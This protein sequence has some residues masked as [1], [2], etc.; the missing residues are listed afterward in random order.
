MSGK[1]PIDDLFARGLRDAEATPPPAVWK[2][3]V[4]E[5]D[6]RGAVKRRSWWGL[7]ALLLLFLGAAGYWTLAD[8][9]RM[10]AGENSQ[11]EAGST[12]GGGA[13]LTENPTSGATVLP[14]QRSTDG[15]ENGTKDMN[16]TSVGSDRDLTMEG[17]RASGSAENALDPSPETNGSDR[18][19]ANLA[20]EKSR[21]VNR[22]AGDIAKADRPGGK[23]R[24]VGGRHNGS[25]P[26]AVKAASEPGQASNENEGPLQ[27]GTDPVGAEGATQ[28]ALGQT[29]AR[30]SPDVHLDNLIPLTTPFANN[31]ATAPGPILQG[32]STPTYLLQKGN[33]WVAAQGEWSMLNGSWK[34]IGEEVPELN[35]SET[36]REGQGLSVVVGRSW[37]S[38]WSLGLGIGANTQRSRFLRRESEPGRSETV[39]DT[40]WTGT[41]VSGEV[42]NYTWDIVN[43]VVAEPGTE[44]ELS[45]TNRYMRLRIAPE[46][47][48]EVVQRKRFTLGARLS[49]VMMIDMGRK[50]NTLVLSTSADTLETLTS[51]TA[52]RALEDASVDGRFPL[53]LAVSAGLEMRYRLSDHWSLAALP[54]FTY[55]MPRAEGAVPA[56]SMNELGGAVRLRYDFRHN[57]RRV[58]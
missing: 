28:E 24:T 44:R 39:V 40:T 35:A 12:P 50:G 14:D 56:L 53:S 32:D 25:T 13:S 29:H 30:L 23:S 6:Q 42:T 18:R 26:E 58:K 19:T 49:P 31:A 11:G 37:L 22:A 46:V 16:T 38:G 48:Y 43:M 4:R 7:A 36:W 9:E 57:E 2:G 52:V 15:Q 8:Q 33:W 3:I 41:A 21:K 5:R 51:A 55:W 20:E 34:G 27:V 10:P 45:A 1:H 54:T 17:S 47:G